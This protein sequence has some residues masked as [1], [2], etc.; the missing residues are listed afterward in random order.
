MSKKKYSSP[1]F[2]EG[3]TPIGPGGDT[4]IGSGEGGDGPMTYHDWLDHYQ[5]DDD[6][7]YDGDNDWDEDDYETWCE[8]MGFDPIWD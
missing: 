2:N 7:D 4:G 8:V 1:V 5:Y 3:I 6:Y